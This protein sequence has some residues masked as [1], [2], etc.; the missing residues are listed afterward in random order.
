MVA[1]DYIY[2]A[3]LVSIVLI[4][5]A[6]FR[7]G[8]SL[9]IEAYCRWRY[10]DYS[11]ILSLEENAFI[12]KAAASLTDAYKTMS[13]KA[14][15]YT[16]CV[17]LG[18]LLLIVMFMPLVILIEYKQSLQ[19]IFA[20]SLL[21]GQL[22]VYEH[23]SSEGAALLLGAALVF[24][25]FIV[26]AQ[27]WF[28]LQANTLYSMSSMS[29]ENR[30]RSTLRKTIKS[31]L[32]R[33]V[34]I[35]RLSKDRE[36]SVDELIR[37]LFN[38]WN[39]GVFTVTAVLSALFS[40]VVYF[41]F[42]AYLRV[43]EMGLN[44]RPFLSNNEYRYLHS[45][46]SRIERDCDVYLSHGKLDASMGYSIILKDDRSLRII[47]GKPNAKNIAA[48]ALIHRNVG[49]EISSVKYT[50]SEPWRV[51]QA[52]YAN[53]LKLLTPPNSDRQT[54]NNLEFILSD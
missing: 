33:L 46:V 29:E 47:R 35:R 45:D 3:V 13:F 41:D 22:E 20:P 5:G 49:F 39:K 50:S 9:A 37:I 42:S 23:T 14:G 40:V 18:L 43:S 27:F 4:A 44:Q 52:N 17:L 36:Y 25:V 12:D 2:I 11:R 7:F 34:R 54:A 53:C 38:R 48:A 1:W 30:R 6:A 16:G 51:D 32:T 8:A 21:A 31:D 15:F 19:D 26:V 24:C 10:E 28:N